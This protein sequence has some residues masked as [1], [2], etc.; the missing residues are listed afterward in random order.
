[1][2]KKLLFLIVS[3]FTLT[4][5]V[6]A[7]EAVTG[8][9]D[10]Y[11]TYVIGKGETIQ[12]HPEIEPENA[13]NK[14][15]TYSSGLETCVT[16][17]NDGKVTGVLTDGS[18]TTS[19]VATTAEGNFTKTYTFEVVDKITIH[20]NGGNAS[21]E[22]VINNSAGSWY[23]ENVENDGF[24]ARQSG[25]TTLMELFAPSDS[26]T[27]GLGRSGYKFAGFYTAAE[28]GELVSIYTKFKDVN[29][30]YAHWTQEDIPVESIEITTGFVPDKL[31]M[32][33]LH[34]AEGEGKVH[35]VQLKVLPA[36][37]YAQAEDVIW[38]SLN[39]DI[40]TVDENG[41][42]T[43]VA[44][45]DATIK[46]KTA[47]TNKEATY[48][49]RVTNAD[50]EIF[51]TPVDPVVK[52]GEVIEFM[53]YQIGPLYVDTWFTMEISDTS[54][55]NFVNADQEISDGKVKGL[56][57]GNV[58]V[59]FKLGNDISK[60]VTLRVVNDDGE[61]HIGPL[62]FMI[63]FE[64]GEGYDQSSSMVDQAV[65]DG[66]TTTINKN[67]FTKKGYVFAGWAVY[68]EKADGSRIAAQ[69]NGEQMMYKDGDD[70]S[71]LSIPE[72]ATLVLVATWVTNPNTGAIVPIAIISLGLVGVYLFL[73]KS[74]KFN[75]IANI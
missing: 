41:L 24:I 32:V 57:E 75:K 59:K 42:V 63:K 55:A 26:H 30:V 51:I 62:K 68:I 9:V 2:K 21:C 46:A 52:V 74:R 33:A 56:K 18:C 53:P 66:E 7:D 1:M 23:F 61:H 19:V 71:K 16:V 5:I 60:E 11:N 28:G 69:L 73:I 6:K 43:A 67:L 35:T 47:A 36:P 12:L 58:T 29:E 65:Y 34:K 37:Y 27:C 44:V 10:A 70:I 22:Y 14:N 3:I 17:T 13:T 49:V 72:G 54:I 15:I 39:P 25:E 45:G 64:G 20:G 40:A 31:K 38:T 48:T 50:I 4:G 8:I